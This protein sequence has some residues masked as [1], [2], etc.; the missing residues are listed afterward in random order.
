MQDDLEAMGKELEHWRII[1]RRRVTELADEEA[2][3]EA[4][5]PFNSELAQLDAQLKEKRSQIRHY[6][7]AVVRN[8]E[9]IERLL[10]Q[11]V[12]ARS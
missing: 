2:T 12:N 1:H 9:K 6:K 11:V 5:V 8:D 4:L 10:E 7:A 3:T